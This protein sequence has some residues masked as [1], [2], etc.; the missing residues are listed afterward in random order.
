MPRDAHDLPYAPVE[1]FRVRIQV[2]GRRREITEG[3][4][5]WSYGTISA[6]VP[7]TLSNTDR[8]VNKIPIQYFYTSVL[9]PKVNA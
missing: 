9:P 3:S 8:C 1:W 6:I 7:F 5:D 2:N 4:V